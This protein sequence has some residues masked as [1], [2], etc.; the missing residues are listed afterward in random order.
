M[1]DTYE[2]HID[3]KFGFKLGK[4]FMETHEMTKNV[5]GDQGMSHTL[6]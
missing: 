1:A 4:K 2:Q 5:Y 3:I 6:L